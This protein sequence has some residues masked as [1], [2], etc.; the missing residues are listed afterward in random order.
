MMPSVPFEEVLSF[1]KETRGILS[2]TS[3]DM[4]DSLKI[5]KS[6]AKQII[7]ILEL[8]GYVKR[9]IE[10][11]DTEWLTT[12]NGETIS[13]SVAPRFSLK[14]V[15][16][17][18]AALAQRIGTINRDRRAAFRVAGAVAFGDFLSARKRVQAADVGVRLESLTHRRKK[19]SPADDQRQFLKQLRAGSA[20]IRVQTYK[21]WMSRRSHLRLV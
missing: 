12:L 21:P 16:E 8:Q 15:K 18:L 20:T 11:G 3:S 17:G 2:W 5:S 6:A 19:E 13:G 14:H 10:A 9:T 4:T 1:L 7:V